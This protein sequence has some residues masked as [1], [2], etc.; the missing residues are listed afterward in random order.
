MEKIVQDI[1]IEQSLSLKYESQEELPSFLMAF[2]KYFEMKE[3]DD[4]TTKE[5]IIVK[6]LN[7]IRI[8]IQKE[9]DQNTIKELINDLFLNALG[10]DLEDE[11]Y[12]EEDLCEFCERLTDRLELYYD[13]SEEDLKEI[14]YQETTARFLDTITP[15]CVMIDF[16]KQLEK[17]PRFYS[18]NGAVQSGKT[19]TMLAFMLASIAAKEKCIIIVQDLTQDA[20][21]FIN[22]SNRMF[23][24]HAKL[25]SVQGLEG[26]PSTKACNNPSNDDILSW[27]NPTGTIQIIVCLANG[28]QLKKILPHIKNKVFNSFIDEADATLNKSETPGAKNSVKPLLTEVALYSKRC[29]CTSATSMGVIFKEDLVDFSCRDVLQIPLDPNYKGFDSLDIHILP[30]P[31]K[32]YR[33]RASC[34]EPILKQDS[35]I[36]KFIEKQ[37]KALPF[38]KSLKNNESHP[39]VNLIKNSMYVDHHLEI[40]KYIATKYADRFVAISYDGKKTT[41][42]SSSFKIRNVRIAGVIG[43]KSKS[44]SHPNILEFSKLNIQQ[45]LQYF[46]DNGG[47]SRFPR[48]M[49]IAGKLADRGINFTS[50]NYEWHLTGQYLRSSYD[51]YSENLIQACRVQGISDDNIGRK[52]WTTKDIYDDIKKTNNLMKEILEEA[53]TVQNEK[54]IDRLKEKEIIKSKLPRRKITRVNNP[55]QIIKKDQETNN[56][57]GN[58]Q[59]YIVDGDQLNGLQKEYYKIIIEYLTLTTCNSEEKWVKRTVLVNKIIEKYSNKTEENIRGALSHMCSKNIKAEKG[60]TF[61]KRSG[62]YEFKLVN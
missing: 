32:K 27:I 14:Q 52:L 36:K 37:S 25:L 60:L 13:C 54:I 34:K 21:Q 58:G 16:T 11:I 51:S 62:E 49:I 61:T 4:R 46:K 28:T 44:I 31:A 20:Q 3:Q 19:R 56:D 23:V 18:L 26:Y 33:F 1:S 2:L 6:G 59:L 22:A 53:S 47:V 55:M 43:Q 7:K 40:I 24:Q 48:F 35:H 39:Q 57:I 41:V 12:I 42:Y 30:T 17:S 15:L 10:I 29:F 50:A 9:K 45:V 38:Y 5:K 8:Y